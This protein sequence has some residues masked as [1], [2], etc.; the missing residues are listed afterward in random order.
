MKQRSRCRWR[1]GSDRERQRL[2]GEIFEA[3][4]LRRH[5]SKLCRDDALIDSCLR[6]GDDEASRAAL[7]HFIAS[8]IRYFSVNLDY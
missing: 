2:L 3:A 5:Q 7:W 8:L 6:G 1:S 4:P